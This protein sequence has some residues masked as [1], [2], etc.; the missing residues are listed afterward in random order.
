MFRYFFGF[1]SLTDYKDAENNGI[2]DVFDRDGDGIINMIDL[3]AD[4]DG[5]LNLSESGQTTGTD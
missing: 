4:N 3:D 2:P 5:I 1:G